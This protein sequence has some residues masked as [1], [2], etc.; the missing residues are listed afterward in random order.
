MGIIS[1]A[2][3]NLFQQ[4]ISKN[5]SKTSRLNAKFQFIHFLLLP[6]VCKFFTA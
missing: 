4:K 3:F 5:F 2:L 6:Q 1:N